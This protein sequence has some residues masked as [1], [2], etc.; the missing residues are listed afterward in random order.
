[1]RT[2]RWSRCLWLALG[3]LA[4]RLFACSQVL[5]DVHDPRS[6]GSAFSKAMEQHQVSYAKSL[7]SDKLWKQIDDWVSRH[8]P[9]SCPFT[10]DFDDDVGFS[11]GGTRSPHSYIFGETHRCA[12]ASYTFNI[13][14]ELSETDGIWKVTELKTLCVTKGSKSSCL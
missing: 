2:T 6:V 11:T 14:L 12:A 7:A 9:L 3:L 8:E 5:V 10:W 4:S 1:M 13:D